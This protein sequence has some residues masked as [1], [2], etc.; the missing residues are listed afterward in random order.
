MVSCKAVIP[1]RI[2]ITEEQQKVG[3]ESES[4]SVRLHFTTTTTT[5]SGTAAGTTTTGESG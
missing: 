4:D 2:I 3:S 1:D 5:K